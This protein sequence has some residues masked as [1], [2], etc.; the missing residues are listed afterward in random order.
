M[1]MPLAYQT[2]DREFA[3]HGVLRGTV[4]AGDA[5]R[6]LEKVMVNSYPNRQDRWIIDNRM[7]DR[8]PALVDVAHFVHTVETNIED[9]ENVSVAWITSVPLSPSLSTML[10][11]LPIRF[12][13]FEDFDEACCWLSWMD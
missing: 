1:A 12:R 4:R 2:L 11:K 8:P 3:N 7:V 13:E 10:C 6:L 9:F 5:L